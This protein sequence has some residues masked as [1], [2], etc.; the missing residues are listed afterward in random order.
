MELNGEIREEL[1]R[2][3]KEAAKGNLKKDYPESICRKLNIVKIWYNIDRTRAGHLGYNHYM[4]GSSG[5][6]VVTENSEH[7]DFILYDSH[8]R[9]GVE[10]PFT[11]PYRNNVDIRAYM[12]FRPGV[13]EENIDKDLL[14]FFGDLVYLFT[15]I[16]N[17]RSMLDFAENSDSLTGI[18]NVLYFTKKYHQIIRN[19]PPDEITV[20]RIN[21][22]KFKNVNDSAGAR[23]GDEAITQY[24]KKLVSFVEEDEC[25]CRLGGDNFAIFIKNEHIEDL[26]EK[27][28]SVPLTNL[29]TAPGKRFEVGAWIGISK[30]EKGE[31]AP[32]YERLNDAFT[33]CEVGKLRLKQRVVYFDKKLAGEINHKREIISLFRPSVRSH[34]FQPFFQPKVDMRTGRIVG[35]ETLCRWIHEGSVIYPDQFIPILDECSLIPD[36]DLAIFEETCIA[37]RQWKNMGLNPKRISTN[38]SKKDL[39]VPG[40]EDRIAEII[41]DQDLSPDDVEIEITENVEASEHERL[42][43]FVRNLKARGIRIAIDDFGTGYSSLSLIHN[44]EADVIKIDRSFVSLL[45]GDE[46]SRILIESII[47]IADR[48]DMSVIAEGVENAEQKDK[49]LSLGCFYAQGYHFGKPVDFDAATRVLEDQAEQE[50][51]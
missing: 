11:Y 40:I 34:E 33:A 23:A 44:I 1:I 9:V 48:L 10:I 28:K 43:D 2:I 31:N 21:L 27:L 36:L 20:I 50:E 14:S 37:I 13:L 16:S 15:S 19:I 39:F 35:F 47:S 41:D 38:F 4:S 45:P 12:G 30:P 26:I 8:E 49:L 29:K 6:P 7:G 42:K 51:R 24:A 18:P 5:T 32:F 17:M 25:A 46:K 22:R 3:V